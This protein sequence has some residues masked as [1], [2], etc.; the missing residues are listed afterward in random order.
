MLVSGSG[1]SIFGAGSGV[2]VLES[3]SGRGDSSRIG[4][5]DP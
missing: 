1:L 5:S 3:G 4:S 2:S